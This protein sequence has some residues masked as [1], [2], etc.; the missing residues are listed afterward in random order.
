VARLLAQF[1]AG[2]LDGILARFAGAG[3][4]FEQTAPGGV[5]KLANQEQMIV[6]GQRQDRDGAG[7]L[8]DLADA[9]ATGREADLVDPDAEETTDKPR[10]TGQRDVRGQV[11]DHR[12]IPAKEGK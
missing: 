4:E 9:G 11:L 5:A 12:P 3:G 10:S 2:G 6:G 1:A 8:D 7:V